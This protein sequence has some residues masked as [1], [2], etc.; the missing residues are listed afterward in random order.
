MT[1]PLDSP[2]PPTLR[3]RIDTGALADNWRALDALSGTA[4]AG[5]AVKADCYGLGI[6]YCVRC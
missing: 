1:A 5:A 6:D 3:L 2:P 4:R